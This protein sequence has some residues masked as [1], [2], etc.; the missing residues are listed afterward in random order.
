ME[1]AYRNPI[2]PT[3]VNNASTKTPRA[4]HA[5]VRPTSAL[6]N[7]RDEATIRRLH[8]DPRRVEPLISVSV[9]TAFAFCTSSNFFDVFDEPAFSTSSGRD[10]LVIWS[11]PS[12][13]DLIV[14]V[15]IQAS[16]LTV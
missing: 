6:L 5:L 16:S 2:P 7:C 10:I 9:M 4:Y 11:G 14:K 8:L 3:R 15:C 13:M 1:Q 12:Q